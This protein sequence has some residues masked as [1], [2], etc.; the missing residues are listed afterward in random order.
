[1]RAPDTLMFGSNRR[2]WSK[3]PN[4]SR[5]RHPRAPAYQSASCADLTLNCPWQA[6]IHIALSDESSEVLDRDFRFRD[7]L[8]DARQIFDLSNSI[9]FL[10]RRRFDVAQTK[11]A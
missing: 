7:G 10:H 3:A 5:E 1:M 8:A 11:G 4:A 9:H 2:T 6:K